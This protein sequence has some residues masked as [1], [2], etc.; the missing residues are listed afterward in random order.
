MTNTSPEYVREIEHTLFHTNRQLQ[1][2]LNK[3]HPGAS[4]VHIEEIAGMDPR[5]RQV[6]PTLDG[7]RHDHKARYEYVVSELGPFERVLDIGCGVGYGSSILHTAGFEVWAMDIDANAI[8]FAKQ[9]FPGP[10]YI[11]GDLRSFTAETMP[12]GTPTNVDAVTIF[13]VLEH[14][15]RGVAVDLLRHVPAPYVYCSVPNETYLPFDKA[16]APFHERHYTEEEFRALLQDAGLKV[17]L[18]K[19]QEGPYSDVGLTP[20]R[21]LVARCVRED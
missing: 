2:L 1:L 15:P 21:T 14:V 16:G 11:H 20:G 5:E 6:A 19:H 3:H 9:Y 10:H 13:E 12:D 18:L 8:E 7:V 4:Y 17:Q